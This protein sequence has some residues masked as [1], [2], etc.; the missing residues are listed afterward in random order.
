MQISK[1]FLVVCTVAGCAV[2]LC[3]AAPDTVSQAQAREALRQ[4][5][6]DLNAQ[7]SAVKQ[8]TAETPK[9]KKK[10]SSAPAAQ[11][12][13][14]EQ[15]V[16]TISPAAPAASAPVAAE[17]TPSSPAPAA[18]ATREEIVSEREAVREKIA[19]LNA[20][21]QGAQPAAWP[22]AEGQKKPAARVQSNE[23]APLEPPP[24]AV[25]AAKEAKLDDLLRRYKADEI[26]AEE[27]HKQRA[28]ILA[29]P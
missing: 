19:E 5:I 24:P 2:S 12:V 3:F 20:Q 10:T 26:T 17:A 4:K 14:Q 16:E 29:E 15:S 23:F 28:H 7:E 13:T 9:A 18:P 21:E 22:R 27:Y 8:T 11:P 6:A 1:V 25:S